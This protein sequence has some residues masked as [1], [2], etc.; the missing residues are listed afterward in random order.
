M[1]IRQ[2]L[3]LGLVGTSLL[4]A[5]IGCISRIKNSE[6]KSS[7]L[8]VSEKIKQEVQAATD[9]SLALRETQIAIHELLDVET[10]VISTASKTLKTQIINKK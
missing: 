6:I 1:T 9:M 3:F 4:L 10:P 5:F 2:R 7:A 8:I